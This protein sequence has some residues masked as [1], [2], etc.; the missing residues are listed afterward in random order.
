M[1]RK[2]LKATEP[3]SLLPPQ[4]GDPGTTKPENVR[5][6]NSQVVKVV[7]IITPTQH[8]AGGPELCI[9]PPHKPCY[10]TSEFREPRVMR[11]QK[12]SGGQPLFS[13]PRPVFSVLHPEN[14]WQSP[15]TGIC[16]HCQTGSSR[17][18]RGCVHGFKGQF[19][20]PRRRAKK[21]D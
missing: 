20:N 18:T 3:P 14:Q 12:Q 13:A 1:G 5:E 2:A 6:Q 21:K 9:S 19:M 16:L 11:K 10:F 4:F 8:M 15:E 17:R 7:R